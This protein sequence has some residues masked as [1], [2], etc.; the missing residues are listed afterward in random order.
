MLTFFI[1]HTSAITEQFYSTRVAQKKITELTQ[2]NRTLKADL[3][4]SNFSK[5]MEILAQE[6]Y[7]KIGKIHYVRILSDTAIAKNIQQ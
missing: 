1:L 6:N 2:E 3:L 5:N 4:S 7:E